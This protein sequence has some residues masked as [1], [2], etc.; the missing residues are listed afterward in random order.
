MYPLTSQTL[1]NVLGGNT[2]KPVAGKD[3]SY[4][5]SRSHQSSAID[6]CVAQYY[7]CQENYVRLEVRGPLSSESGYFKF[8]N[9]VVCYGQPGMGQL[10]NTSIGNLADT[11]DQLIVQHGI[12]YLP[13][14][15]A[16]VANNL[17]YELYL[18]IPSQ[19]HLGF[20]A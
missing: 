10:S 1:L 14:D 19:R 2:I 18:L 7:R 15:P 13:F 4:V 12:A 20:G 17:R 11:M 16:Q 5:R 8:G 6:K 3:E 9:D